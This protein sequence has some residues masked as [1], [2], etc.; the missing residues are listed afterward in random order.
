MGKSEQTRDRLQEVA[1]DLIASQGF[2]STTVEQI[3]RAAG[4]SQMT[5]FRHFATKDAVVLS[6]PFD[7]RI[8]AAVAAQPPATPP[9]ARAC[10]GLRE[11]INELTG[12]DEHQAR[13]RVRI[14]AE[15]PSLAA[16][17]WANT[18]ATQQVL[19]MVLAEH[20][21]EPDARVAAAA[22]MGALVAALLDWGSRDDDETL[23]VPLLRALQVLDP[24]S[25]DGGRQ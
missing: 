13:Q 15:T 17:V 23:R 24:P 4:V 9:L 2:D 16:G 8:A 14:V 6:D 12:S 22:T 20:A 1:L 11:S 10:R 18:T 19:S 7:P 3:A 21:P 25:D 5:F